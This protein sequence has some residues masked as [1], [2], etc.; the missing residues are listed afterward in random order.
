MYNF[1]VMYSLETLKD[2]DL[3]VEHKEKEKVV[4]KGESKY[5]SF[6]AIYS[7]LK[8][9]EGTDWF[10]LAQYQQARLQE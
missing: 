1:D 10:Q 2:T 6:F 8:T 4:I 9:I 7:Y 5:I 3:V